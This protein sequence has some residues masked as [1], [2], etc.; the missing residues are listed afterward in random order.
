MPDAAAAITVSTTLQTFAQL[1]FALVGVSL[2]GAHAS[3]IS[4]NALRSSTL[5]ASGLLALQLV[6]FI[7]CSGGSFQQADARSVRFF[8]KRDWSNG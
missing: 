7:L 5:I 3:H 2:L 1:G 4:E 8:G 6:G